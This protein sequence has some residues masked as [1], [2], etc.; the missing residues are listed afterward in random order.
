M[1]K[2]FKR[3]IFPI[4]EENINNKEKENNLQRIECEP[5][6]PTSY[7]STNCVSSTNFQ[8]CRYTY[9]NKLCTFIVSC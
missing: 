2:K 5:I 9:N 3:Y 8:S 4:G 1:E 6:L 7:L